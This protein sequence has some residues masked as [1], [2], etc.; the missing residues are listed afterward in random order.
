MSEGCIGRQNS[1][2]GNEEEAIR[3]QITRKPKLD[4]EVEGE[5]EHAEDEEEGAEGEAGLGKTADR[6]E[7]T[8]GDYTETGFGARKVERPDRFVAGEVTAE[9]G[10]LVFHPNGEFVAIAPEIQGAEQENPIAE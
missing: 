2:I 8:G 1:R 10:E 7:E 3:K 4:E 6:V 5:E 9:G